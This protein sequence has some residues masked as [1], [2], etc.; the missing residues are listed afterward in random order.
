MDEWLVAVLLG[1]I[2]GTLEWLPVSSEGS[3]A[4]ALTALDV[5]ESAVADTQFALFLHLGT[6]VAAMV[7]Y[8]AEVGEL[9]AD[10]P[11]WRPGDWF[12]AEQ[13][14]LTFVVVAMGASFATGGVAYLT[15]ETVVSSLSGGAFV[16]LI[17]ALLVGTGLLQWTAQDRAIERRTEIDLLDAVLVGALQGLAILP[18]VSRSGTTV[19]ALL[20]RG[21]PGEDSLRL[22]FLLSIPAA[23]AAGALV[24]V[25]VGVPSIAPGPAALALA[26]SAVVGFLTVG[27][28][29]ALVRRVAFWAVCVGFGGL[30][31]VGGAL[32]IV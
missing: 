11:S 25:E 9:L 22:S 17:G 18:G 20:L 24:F 31:V 32:L 26:V 2:Q 13:A 30:A 8:R 5:G 23:L 10:V 15:L 29:V 6:A 27:A 16:A 12:A 7:Y 1:L 14:T 4:L 28:L 19:S 21:H 3:V